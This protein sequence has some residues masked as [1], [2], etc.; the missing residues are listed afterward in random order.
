MAD[1]AGDGSEGATIPTALFYSARRLPRSRRPRLEDPDIIFAALGNG[2]I[3]DIDDDEEEVDEAGELD[4]A[5]DGDWDNQQELSDSSDEEQPDKESAREYGSWCRKPF[6]KP[7][8]EFKPVADENESYRDPLLTPYEYFSKAQWNAV[9]KVH[10][11]AI[12]QFYGLPRNSP[13]AATY[14]ET[15]SWPVSLRAMLTALNHIEC[16][17][18]S[19]TCG[20]LL[21]HLKAQ[22][23]SHMGAAVNQLYKLLGPPPPPPPPRFPPPHQYRPPRIDA[24]LPG[25]RSKRS[26]PH[27]ALRQEVASKVHQEFAGHTIVY[28]DGSVREE[29][30]GAACIAP[31][32]PAVRQLRLNTPA[33]SLTA[34]LAAISLAAD[35]LAANPAVTRAA[36]LTDS[37]ASLQALHS[38]ERGSRLL[39]IAALKLHLLGVRGCNISMQWIPSHISVDGNEAA[40]ELARAALHPTVPLSRIVTPYDSARLALRRFVTRLHPDPRV[41]SATAM[42]TIDTTR[43]ARADYVLLLRLRSGSGWTH[44]RLR[45]HRDPPA[46]LC[47]QCGSAYTLEHILCVCPASSRERLALQQGYRDLGLPCSALSEVLFPAAP[48]ISQTAALRHL[49]R[50][51]SE[52]DLRPRL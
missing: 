31:S 46:A 22:T 42:T 33:S 50:F 49:L 7:A 19:G 13:T 30:A 1:G 9:D 10:R 37:R 4:D 20:D 40:D 32:L 6:E 21:A 38:P 23:R 15:R 17:Q 43:F 41:A 34:E 35:V 28:T 25:V 36:I 24:V 45:R 39:R 29:A 5:V 2:D 8:A 27:C 16:M 51:I 12:R 26:T 52:C 14:A 18:R 44:D 48:P 47:A 11:G 3:S